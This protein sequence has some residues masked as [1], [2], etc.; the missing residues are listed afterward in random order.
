MELLDVLVRS[1]LFRNVSPENTEKIIEETGIK[2]KEYKSGETLVKSGSFIKDC[3][4]ITWGEAR[5]G[6]SGTLKQGDVFGIDTAAAGAVSIFDIVTDNGC[7]CAY[8]NYGKLLKCSAKGTAG[9][10]RVTENMLRLVSEDSIAMKERLSALTKSN[11]REKLLEYFNIQSILHGGNVLS[12]GMSRYE[13]ASYLCVDRCSLSREL[14][15]LKNEG[16]IETD[17]QKI[18][19]KHKHR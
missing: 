4:I 9:Y 10:Q 1:G 16:I 18:I 13:I 17:K 11:L 19:L 3:G 12:L 7:T 15:K 14:T 5:I 2:V 8:I 6:K